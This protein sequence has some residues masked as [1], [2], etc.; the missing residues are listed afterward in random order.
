MRNRKKRFFHII[1]NNF[2]HDLFKKKCL[3]NHND[4]WSQSSPNISTKTELHTTSYRAISTAV[5]AILVSWERRPH[6]SCSDCNIHLP[7]TGYR[8]WRLLCLQFG[9][10]LWRTTAVT[11]CCWRHIHGTYLRIY[12]FDLREKKELRIF[13]C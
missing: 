8:L 2:I 4:T 9:P 7:R 10:N 12:N 3:S 6:Y 1:C 13:W 5:V 11:W